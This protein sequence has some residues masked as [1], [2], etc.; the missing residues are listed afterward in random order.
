M[1]K[2]DPWSDRAL[3][4]LILKFRPLEGTVDTVVAP[5]QQHISSTGQ[6]EHLLKVTWSN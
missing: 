1:P 4:L 3:E 2:T 5:M 6:D